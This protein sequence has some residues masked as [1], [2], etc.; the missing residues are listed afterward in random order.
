MVATVRRETDLGRQW[1]G[2]VEEKKNNHRQDGEKRRRDQT[3]W[4]EQI[5]QNGAGQ[6]GLD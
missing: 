3:R 1:C 4:T 5:W 2:K 6:R